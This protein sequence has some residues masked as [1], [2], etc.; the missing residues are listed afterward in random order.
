M[1]YTNPSKQNEPEMVQ[2][3]LLDGAYR[4]IGMTTT[5]QIIMPVETSTDD[6]RQVNL[7]QDAVLRLVSE[8]LKTLEH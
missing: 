7:T 8:L 5:D 4:V 3:E 2:E 6:D 1:V